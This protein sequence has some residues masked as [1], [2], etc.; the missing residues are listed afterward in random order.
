MT[1]S[2]DRH[3]SEQSQV[4][5]PVGPQR[6]ALTIDVEDYFQVTAF[7]DVVARDAW[8]DLPSRVE[9]NT[10]AMLR[11]FDD[12][13]VKATFFVLGWIA[14]R[15]PTL[16]EAIAA[17]GHEV[18]SHGYSHR[19][20][21]EQTPDEFRS[22]TDRSKK[23]LE[24][25]VSMPVSG[26]RA[27]TFSITQNSLWAL[28]ILIECGFEYDSSI[29]PIRHDRYGLAGGPEVP[30]VVEV[31]DAEILE[32]PMSTFRAGPLRIPVAGGGYFRLYPYPL[33]RALLARQSA[34]QAAPFVFY[35]H[36]WEIDPDQPRIEAGFLSRFRHYLNLGRC[37]DRL[38]RLLADFEFSTMRSAF[39][40]FEQRNPRM[41]RHRYAPVPQSDTK[42][43]GE[44]SQT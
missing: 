25:I 7:K 29:F 17:Q 26:Y 34:K 11:L 27:A 36:P 21:Y 37:E 23:L 18:A 2:E 30:H 31:G 38:G 13:G 41:P 10:H 19:L 33:T 16:V 1:A 28:Q 40:A 22:E 8:N 4:N 3:H 6:H 39:E 35:A 32:F 20:I 14:E 9:A 12:R 42:P 15:F 44:L 43:H 24:D 5:A